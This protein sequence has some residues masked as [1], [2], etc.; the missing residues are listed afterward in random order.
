MIRLMRYLFGFSTFGTFIGLYVVLN[1]VLV[2]A[3]ALFAWLVPIYLSTW[4]PSSTRVA[5]EA[6]A[7]I[8]SVSGYLLGAQIG[9]LSV[10][11]LAL[12]LVTLIAQR[13]GSSTD[14]QVYYYESF[15][16]EL[17]ASCVALA[18]VLCV[19]L[20]WPMQALLQWTGLG[21]GIATFKLSLLGAHLVWLLINMAG[22][23]FFIATTFRFVQRSTR[24]LLRERYTAN[25]VM[26]RELTAR[27]RRHMYAS[28]SQE[29][30]VPVDTNGRDERPSVTFGIELGEPRNVEIKT[31]FKR[32]M[33]L[34]DVRMIWV[35]WVLRRWSKRCLINAVTQPA[36]GIAGLRRQAPNI[37]FTPHFDQALTGQVAWCR[38]RGGAPLTALERFVLRRAFVFRRLRNAR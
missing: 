1:I 5:E 27:L 10:I 20:F 34:I 30:F 14:V 35:R 6:S 29:L 4:S 26:P 15:S 21:A 7:N 36:S 25:V 8:M 16:F 19:Q 9:L 3:E 31:H 37:C 12:A 13:E 28:A 23:A 24:E 18:A 38:R 33:A 22:V 17:V 2:L 11:S 32:P